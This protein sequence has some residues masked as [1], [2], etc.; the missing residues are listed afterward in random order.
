MRYSA[1]CSRKD[2]TVKRNKAK[3]TISSEKVKRLSITIDLLIYTKRYT[4]FPSET[5]DRRLFERKSLQSDRKTLLSL[6]GVFSLILGISKPPEMFM[7]TRQ[8]VMKL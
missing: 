8:K 2:P 6:Q 5:R 7:K 1:K 4:S 3:R